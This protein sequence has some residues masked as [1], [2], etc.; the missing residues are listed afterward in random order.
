MDGLDPRLKEVCHGA[1][2]T[3]CI[4]QAEEL[5]PLTNNTS[6]DASGPL[7]KGGDPDG[8]LIVL[9][10]AGDHGAVRELVD[11][12]LPKI[13]AISRRMLGTQE[14]AEEVAQ[15][16]FLRV[17]RHAG[18]WVPGKAK[19]STWM[20][21]VALNL[22]YDRLRKKREVAM[23]EVPER[24][25]EALDPAQAL[26]A[27]QVAQRV[28]Q[29]LRELPERQRGA[30]ILCHYQGVSNIEAAQI[31]EISVEALESLLSRGRRGLKVKL[32]ADAK[33]LVAHLDA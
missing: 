12:H 13:I 8:D 16:V 2:V 23:D 32:L 24:I 17:W 14:D 1:D 28:D 26:H 4:C 15:E 5:L 10:A 11:R 19:F 29:A 3:E 21:R 9:V 25:D 20:H 33:D 27:S 31:M 22:C 6:G 30:I 7:L 18:S